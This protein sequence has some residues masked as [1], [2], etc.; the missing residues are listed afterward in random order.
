[1]ATFFTKLNN[2][3]QFIQSRY[4]LTLPF[5]AIGQGFILEPILCFP[6]DN[7]FSCFRRF[8]FAY[9]SKTSQK[10]RE[11]FGKAEWSGEAEIRKNGLRDTKGIIVG[12]D[13]KGKFLIFWRT[14]ICKC[15]CTD[16][17]R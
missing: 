8:C 4:S 11:I 15:W 10:Q 3:I 14:T 17:K 12:K 13:N 1:M 5:K 2:A 7:Y 16:P 6:D 9:R